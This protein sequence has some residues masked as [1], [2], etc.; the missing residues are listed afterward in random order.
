MSSSV[1]NKATSIE[2]FKHETH[3][4]IIDASHLDEKTR[5][6]LLTNMTEKP[7]EAKF[8]SDTISI[9]WRV[10]KECCNKTKLVFTCCVRYAREYIAAITA[11]HLNFRVLENY[12]LKHNVMQLV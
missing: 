9:Q 1:Y 8:D 5:E 6:Q 11:K 12:N 3:V 7:M 2:C 10:C 4:L